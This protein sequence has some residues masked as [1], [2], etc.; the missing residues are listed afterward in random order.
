MNHIV[1]SVGPIWSSSYGV[2]PLQ[3]PVV[4][5]ASTAPIVSWVVLSSLEDSNRGMFSEVTTNMTY[6]VLRGLEKGST[7]T[8]KVAG[9]NN[10]QPGGPLQRG[11]YSETAEITTLIDCKLT[12]DIVVWQECWLFMVIS[13]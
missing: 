1:S 11:P 4:D 12:W 10:V 5:L 3:R 8:V 6:I 9:K 7:Y 13:T 2:C